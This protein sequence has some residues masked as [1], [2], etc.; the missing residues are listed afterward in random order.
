MHFYKG[1]GKILKRGANAPLKHPNRSSSIKGTYFLG[2]AAPLLNTLQVK[3][4]T[5][6]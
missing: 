4:S 2:E 1:K 6:G 3:T 5:G